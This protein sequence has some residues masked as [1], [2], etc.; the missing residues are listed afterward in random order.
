MSQEAAR[1]TGEAAAEALLMAIEDFRSRLSQRVLTIASG[2]ET[3][4]AGRIVSSPANIAR[5]DELISAMKGEFLDVE[6]VEAVTTYVESM[7]SVTAQVSRSFDAFDGLDEDVLT[8]IS[9]RYKLETAAAITDPETYA[10][11]L[12]SP[13]ADRLIYAVATAEV[14]RNALSGASDTVT[15]DAIVAPVAPIVESAPIMMQRAETAAAIE[16]VGAEF[17]FFQG[18]PIKSTRRWCKEREGKYWHI[19]EIR[20]WGRQAKAGKEWD[21]MVE[22]T[23]ENTIFIHLGGWFGLRNSCRHILVPVLRSAVPKEDLDRMREKGLI[24]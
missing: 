21:G 20:E 8:A 1:S 19:E 7:D 12:W 23:D 11:A 10:R 16:Q 22:G 24:E 18:R 4:S 5:V 2:I 3:D 6:F 14:L 9:R 17:F 15:T 13:M